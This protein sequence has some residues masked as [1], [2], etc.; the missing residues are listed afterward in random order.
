MPTPDELFPTHLVEDPDIVILITR[1]SRPR[2]LFPC[3]WYGYKAWWQVRNYCQRCSVPI[4]GRNAAV[5]LWS[6]QEVGNDVLLGE[7]VNGVEKFFT[8]SLLQKESSQ[9]CK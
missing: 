5:T 2:K 9:A 8:T 1:G 4:D 3:R 6:E 7:W